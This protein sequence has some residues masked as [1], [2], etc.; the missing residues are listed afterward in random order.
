[1]I[2]CNSETPVL[3]LTRYRKGL[4]IVFML[5]ASEPE[6]AV[7]THLGR[8]TNPSNRPLFDFWNWRYRFI[9]IYV[10][11]KIIDIRKFLAKIIREFLTNK[12]N[13][14]HPILMMRLINSY[15]FAPWIYIY[16][17]RL[18]IKEGLNPLN[19]SLK[20]NNSY[21]CKFLNSHIIPFGKCRRIC[22]LHDW[23]HEFL[24]N[25]IHEFQFILCI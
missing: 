9:S 22:L 11:T 16:I 15:I 13:I 12:V 20:N 23:I 25:P 6:R 24:N 19:P 7:K 5:S 8:A 10:L 1:M 4:A 14:T 18:V 3:V 2:V 17:Y 21:T